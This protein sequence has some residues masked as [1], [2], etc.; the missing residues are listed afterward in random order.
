MAGVTDLPF[1]K[2]CVRYGAAAAVSEMLT[3]NPQLWQTQKSQK[4]MDHSDE[5]GIR[6]IQI[7]GSDAKLMADAAHLNASMGAQMIDIN[8]GCP[9]KKVCHKAAGSALL[10]NPSQVQK[11][12]D[13]V[14][15]AVDIPVTLKI[16]TG[17]EPDNKNALQIAQIAEQSGIAALSIHGRT[18]ACKFNGKAE[19]KTIKTVKAA[20]QI[21]VIANGDIRSPQQAKQVLDLRLPMAL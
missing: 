11:I 13:A 8:M 20:V 21:P 10:A 16:R 7:V 6:W 12:L 14:V 2:L 3:A 15:A 17:T 1:R 18:R 5:A 19:Y 4:R 9:A